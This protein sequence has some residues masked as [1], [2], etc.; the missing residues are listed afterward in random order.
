MHIFFTTSPNLL[1]FS[2]DCRNKGNYGVIWNFMYDFYRKEERK[3]SGKSLHAFQYSQ[4]IYHYDGFM[5]STAKVISITLDS[6]VVRS[7]L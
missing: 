2:W 3:V 7:W 1:I 5:I 6:D 4:A